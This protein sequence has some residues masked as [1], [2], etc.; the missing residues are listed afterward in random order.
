MLHFRDRRFS[1][2]PGNSQ[3]PGQNNKM[4]IYFTSLVFSKLS[5][6]SDV[7]MFTC[8]DSEDLEDFLRTCENRQHE[9]ISTT[10]LCSFGNRP[11]RIFLAV[12]GLYRFRSC[13]ENRCRILK[14]P[15]RNILPCFSREWQRVTECVGRNRIRDA[16]ACLCPRIYSHRS[17]RMQ[18]RGSR[19][20]ERSRMIR[21]YETYGVL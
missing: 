12:D 9:K 6:D 7:S 18:V 13:K 11:G 16:E 5:D 1:G 8:S 2:K 17:D 10:D 21:F 20:E 4:N 3:K 19:C 15:H 14:N